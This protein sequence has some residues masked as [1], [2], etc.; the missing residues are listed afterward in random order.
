MYEFHASTA[1]NCFEVLG[2]EPEG[3][4]APEA[5]ARLKKYGTN[6]LPKPK[7][8]SSFLRFLAQFNNVLIYVLLASALITAA[9]QHFVDTAVVLAVVIANASIGFI[10]EGRAEKAMASIRQPSSPHAD[11]LAQR[12]AVQPSSRSPRS[13]RHCVF[14]GR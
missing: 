14:R 12:H 7:E 6:T 13:R 2:C 5:T 8:R 10:Q 9:L 1:K 3:L 4:T 11:C